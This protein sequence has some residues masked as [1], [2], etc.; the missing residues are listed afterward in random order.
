MREKID[1]EAEQEP[2]L[3]FGPQLRKSKFV[4]AERKGEFKR[5]YRE[6]AF[7]AFTLRDRLTKIEKVS[8]SPVIVGSAQDKELKARKLLLAR[9]LREV[10]SKAEA[11][12][13]DWK[14]TPQLDKEEDLR[15]LAEQAKE[16]AEEHAS[17]RGERVELDLTVKVLDLGLVALQIVGDSQ[18]GVEIGRAFTSTLRDLTPAKA[19]QLAKKQKEVL[20]KS[21]ILHRSND[22][23]SS[24]I[25]K[26]ETTAKT[27]NLDGAIL[28]SYEPLIEGL[29]GK[30]L[31]MQEAQGHLG[32]TC[33]K[34]GRAIGS[35]I[36][37]A[38]KAVQRVQE[39][40][41]RTASTLKEREDDAIYSTY[42]E[43]R[44][45]LAR[46]GGDPADLLRKMFPNLT[47]R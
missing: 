40:K 32:T 1:S 34:T 44:G 28:G 11:S 21:R 26:L 47:R 36:T 42:R 30:K 29:C 18:A 12:G 35:I 37:R 5:F 39:R 6:A 24:K 27:R 41:G 4:E 20:Q 7:A 14:E 15:W 38:R 23:S 45:Y 9:L 13:I 10:V 31:T 16:A 8:R 33:T 2:W 22:T 25:R 43:V 46:S 17:A 3:K 19:M